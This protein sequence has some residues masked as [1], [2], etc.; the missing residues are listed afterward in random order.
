MNHDYS[1]SFPSRHVAIAKIFTLDESRYL[2]FGLNL[3]I[4]KSTKLAKLLYI[5]DVESP[6]STL[7]TG[8]YGNVTANYNGHKFKY[9][10]TIFRH[11]YLFFC[12]NF[13]KTFGNVGPGQDGND[14]L[15]CRGYEI[16]QLDFAAEMFNFTYG[17]AAPPSMLLEHYNNKTGEWSGILGALINGK[18][19]VTILNLLNGGGNRIYYPAN[20]MH[21]AVGVQ[22]FSAAPKKL[23]KVLA[24]VFPFEQT[25]WPFVLGA[26]VLMSTMFRIMTILHRKMDISMK[27]QNLEKGASAMFGFSAMVGENMR[28]ESAIYH[29]RS[30]RYARYIRI[31]YVLT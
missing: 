23:S 6:P 4:G 27:R 24:L 12:K 11:T 26:G 19:D 28:G 3:G 2:V 13:L 14:Y 17:L 9:C 15:G 31:I 30:L 22:I 7:E 16:Y 5:W 25:L 18:V 1:L 10:G 29:R 21:P 20:N 8:F